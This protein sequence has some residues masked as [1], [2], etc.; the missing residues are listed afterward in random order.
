MRNSHRP[1]AFVLVIGLVLTGAY[2]ISAQ[3]PRQSPRD[4][5]G[6]PQIDPAAMI[7]RMVDQNVK[8]LNLSDEETAIL[9]PK[10][11]NLL[12]TRLERRERVRN[13]TQALRTAIDAKDDA[14]IKTELAELKAKRKKDRAKDEQLEK[15]LIELLSVNQEAQLTVAGVVNSDG[16]GSFFRGN[17]PRRT[18]GDQ[19]RLN[20]RQQ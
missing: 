20:R 10:I 8:R 14:Q 19:Q 3:Q 4:R 6:D 1:I 5:R 13:L 9:K 18:G 12:Q 15:E 16:T 11:K 7:E 17:R 2:F